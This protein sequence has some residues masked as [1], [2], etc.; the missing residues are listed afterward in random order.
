MA[1]TRFLL[2]LACLVLALI[3]IDLAR[4]QTLPDAPPITVYQEA[5]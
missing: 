1:G 4:A 2:F 5:G 3:P